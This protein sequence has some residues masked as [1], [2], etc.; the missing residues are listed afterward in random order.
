MNKTLVIIIVLIVFLG[1]RYL[2]HKQHE[3]DNEQRMQQ[4]MADSHN[5]NSPF[6]IG[7]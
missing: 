7:K 1:G 6:Y 4:G 3:V 5:P 2:I